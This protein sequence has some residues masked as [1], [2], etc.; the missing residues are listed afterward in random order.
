MTHEELVEMLKWEM[1]TDDFLA[2]NNAWCDK[3][4]YPE[5]K[6]YSMNDFITNMQEAKYSAEDI[7]FMIMQGSFVS[8]DSWYMI[9]N[10]KWIRTFNDMC[11]DD[12]CDHLEVDLIADDILEHP[13]EYAQYITLPDNA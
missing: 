6:A 4:N 2:I 9:V 11:Y 13:E 3:H 8:V 10:N 12:L 1:D 7:L 5:L